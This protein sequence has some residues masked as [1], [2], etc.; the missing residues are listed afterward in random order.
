MPKCTAKCVSWDLNDE[1]L[2]NFHLV[3]EMILPFKWRQLETDMRLGGKKTHLVLNMIGYC[4]EQPVALY[5]HDQN[6]NSFIGS[7]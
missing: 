2:V 3:S 1:S 4:I 7:N 6:F 5:V